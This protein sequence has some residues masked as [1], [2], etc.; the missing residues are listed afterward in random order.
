MPMPSGSPTSSTGHCPVSTRPREACR[1]RSLSAAGR[2]SSCSRTERS[3]WPSTSVRRLAVALAVATAV[4]QAGCGGDDPVL[5]VGV[6][7]ECSGLFAPTAPGALAGASLPLL[8]RGA[9]KGDSPG[10]VRN[11]RVAGTRIEL[12]PACTEASRFSRLISETRWLV[13]SRGVDVVVGPLGPPDGPVV[14][15]LA[16][17]YPAVTFLVGSGPAQEVTLKDPQPNLFRLTPE[18]AQ[19]VAGLGAYA[20]DQLGWRRAVVVAE[21]WSNGWEVTAGF[22]AE[23]CSLGGRIVERDFGS[24]VAPDPG[25]A[26][27]RHAAA[28]DGV[29]VLTTATPAVAYVQA[30]ANVVGARLA[31]RLVL[32]G[33]PFYDPTTIAPPDVDTS[34]VVIG[35]VVP[36]DPDDEAM[37]RFRDALE[38]AYPELATSVATQDPTFSSYAAVEAI[39]SALEATGGELGDGQSALRDALSRLELDLPYGPVHLDANRQAVTRNTLE[40]VR[41]RADGR[42]EAE[43]LRHVEGVE[44][45]FGGRFGADTPSPSWT[46]PACERAAPPP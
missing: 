19:M 37:G 31:Q 35:G 29:A 4:V 13:E 23:F 36:L 10:E 11:A 24:L 20:F 14:R 43:L 32:S 1:R 39:A 46:E 40:R 18:G 8:D 22:V 5:R 25:A 28:A 9:R 16:R 3:G 7:A 38:G 30:Y 27:Q 41:R 45:G 17:R 26:A 12:V 2:R 21:G 15:E 34:G 33:P 6:F 44:Q 42:A